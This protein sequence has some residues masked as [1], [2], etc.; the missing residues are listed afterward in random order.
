MDIIHLDKKILIIVET[1][2]IV[3]ICIGFVN[4]ASYPIPKQPPFDPAKLNISDIKP[5]DGVELLN[6]TSYIIYWNERI[7]M[8][9]F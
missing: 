9:F 7:A 6:F 5:D 1:I 2:L 4:A 8:G 3:V